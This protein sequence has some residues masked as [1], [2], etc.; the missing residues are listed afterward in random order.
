MRT[1]TGPEPVGKAFEVDLVDL[2]EDRHY[3][4]LNDFVLQ[5]RNAYWTLA[6]I[7][8]RNVDSPRGLCPIRSTVHPVVQIDNPILQAGFILV[9][10]HAIDSWCRFRLQSVE[11]VTEQI[12]AEMVKQSG[13]AFL[14]PF[15]CCF[16]HTAQSLGHGFPALCRAHVRLNDV[17]LHVV[18]QR[19]R[20]LRLRRTDQSTRDWRGCRV[21]FLPTGTESAS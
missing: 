13:E 4:L 15:T 10:R 18:S 7:R 19:A 20:V 1:A 11:A 21:A 12:D 8:L 16:S 5:S 3:S 14:F 6:S 17:L 2:I 9:P